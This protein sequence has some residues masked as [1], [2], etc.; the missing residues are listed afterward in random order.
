MHSRY[1][2]IDC[3]AIGP[4]IDW[5]YEN[6]NMD[7]EDIDQM[8][9]EESFYKVPRA[10]KVEQTKLFDNKEGVYKDSKQSKTKKTNKSTKSKKKAKK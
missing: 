6:L 8:L 2:E 1:C 9:Y 3:E 5:C 4:V 7:I 10:E